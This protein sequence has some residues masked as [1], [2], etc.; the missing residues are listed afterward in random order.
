MSIWMLTRT[1]AHGVRHVPASR[2]TT[3]TP[4]ERIT[5]R[6]EIEAS[7]ELFIMIA[8]KPENPFCHREGNTN[9]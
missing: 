6:Q 7:S 4:K 2:L 1:F 9:L 5:E 8:F 3:P